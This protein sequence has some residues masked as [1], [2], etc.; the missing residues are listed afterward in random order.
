LIEARGPKLILLQDS[1]KDQR[2][3]RVVSENYSR[4]GAVTDVGVYARKD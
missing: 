4:V 1:L 3:R 2:V